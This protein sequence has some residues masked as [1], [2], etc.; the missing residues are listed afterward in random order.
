MNYLQSMHIEI[1]IITLVIILGLLVR[2]NFIKISKE[3]NDI[4]T[5]DVPLN[6]KDQTDIN[7]TALYIAEDIRD[8]SSETRRS[9][10]LHITDLL[11]RV[12]KGVTDYITRYLSSSDGL[13]DTHTAKGL[14]IT[15]LY[16]SIAVEL[17]NLILDNKGLSKYS[18]GVLTQVLENVKTICNYRRGV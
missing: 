11:G 5:Y 12:N 2:R 17:D 1:I 16:E 13:I 3:Y 9:Q 10:K 7:N 8:H 14:K 18:R 15:A 6:H 4:I